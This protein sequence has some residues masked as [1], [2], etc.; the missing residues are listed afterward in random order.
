[1]RT[2]VCTRL[3]EALNV[4][5]RERREVGQKSKPDK[6][7]D[8]VPVNLIVAEVKFAEAGREHL[9]QGVP[10]LLIRDS[11]RAAAL[12]EPNM[13]QIVASMLAKSGPFSGCIGTDF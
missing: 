3:I 11:K 12:G 4:D 6:G 2:D 5:G 9:V 13:S 7:D 1:M 10:R 8:V